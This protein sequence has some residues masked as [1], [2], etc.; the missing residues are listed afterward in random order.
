MPTKAPGRTLLPALS[1]VV[2]ALVAGGLL[3][4][5][6]T[7]S[8]ERGSVTVCPE[9]SVEDQLDADGRQVCTF[10]NLNGT[11]VTFGT[12]VRNDG[13]LP[14]TVSDVPLEPLD[15]VGFTPSEV[16]VASAEDDRI[17]E[18]FDA[19]RLAPGAERL[20]QVVG[21]LPACEDREQGGATTFTDLALRVRVLGIP[22][23][24]AVPFEPAI[25]LVSEPC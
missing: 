9:G 3:W 23:D 1:V 25:R 8:T 2:L 17:L 10:S 7:V 22:Q 5:V 19:F 18:E 24:A 15:L 12:A 14:V 4:A 20:V 16:H 21:E 6:T 11:E 13:P